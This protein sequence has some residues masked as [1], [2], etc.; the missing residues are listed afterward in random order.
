MMFLYFVNKPIF[1]VILISSTSIEDFIAI[2][3]NSA[4]ASSHNGQSGFVN[5]RSLVGS[6]FRDKALGGEV[7]VDMPRMQNREQIDNVLTVA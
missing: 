2:F 7:P 1:V 6:I 5:N 3:S 4:L